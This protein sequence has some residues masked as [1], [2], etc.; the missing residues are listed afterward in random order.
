VVK[1]NWMFSFGEVPSSA[2]AEVEKTPRYVEAGSSLDV[3]VNVKVRAPLQA[4]W[5]GNWLIIR[6]KKRKGV[7]GFVAIHIAVEGNLDLRR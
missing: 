6:A 4:D 1:F 5:T 3:G 7:A 2:V